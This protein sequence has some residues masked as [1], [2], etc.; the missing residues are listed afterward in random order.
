MLGA[1]P[2]ISGGYP[3]MSLE[4]LPWAL[5]GT[6]ETAIAADLWTLWKSWAQAN[7]ALGPRA[8]EPNPPAARG[9]DLGCV[10]V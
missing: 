4:P 1:Y 2:D 10:C 3:T 5:P 8:P 9:S 7:W 6:L